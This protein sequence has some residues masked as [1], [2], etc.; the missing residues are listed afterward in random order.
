MAVRDI[1]ALAAGRPPTTDDLARW[2]AADAAARPARVGRLRERLEREGVDAYFGIRRENTRYLT[3]FELGEGEEKVAGNSGQFFIG[4]DEVIVLA[5]SRYTLQAQEQCPEARM[6]RVYNTLVARWP[7]LIASLGRVRR[8]A[9]EAGFVSHALWGRLAGASPDVELVPA[10]GW[11]EELRATKEP[12]ELERVAAACAVADAALTRLLPEIVPG[13]T[14]HALALRLEWEMRT[15][16]AEALAFDVA[17]LAGPRAA[18]PHGSPGERRVAAGEVLLFDFGAQVAGY[19]SDMTR[20]LFVGEP[21]ARDREIY[22]LVA[23]A[24]EAAFEALSRAAEA[25]E[26][27]AARSIDEAARSVIRD[28]GHGDHFGHGLGHGIGLA[29]HEL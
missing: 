12:A 8:V 24:Q 29:T 6:E 26:R 19:R 7:E 20:T 25:G 28:A 14:E 4:R 3:G 18:L 16:G 2:R 10:E 5:D 13:A 1:V 17:C 9:V 22:E 27:P 11:V 21:S 15:N 23:A